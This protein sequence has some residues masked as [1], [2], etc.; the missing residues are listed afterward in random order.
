MP[1]IRRSLLTVALAAL[2]GHRAEAL[3]RRPVGER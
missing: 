3:V 2:T 1:H